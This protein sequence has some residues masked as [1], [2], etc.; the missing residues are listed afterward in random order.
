MTDDLFGEPTTTDISDEQKLEELRREFRYR[1]HVFPRLIAKGRLGPPVARE[2][3]LILLSIIRDYEEKTN[4][5]RATRSSSPREGKPEA[6][7]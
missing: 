4:V 2:R 1:K 6:V 3:Q 7:S 5:R